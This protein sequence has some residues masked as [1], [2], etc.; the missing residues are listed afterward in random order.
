V[1]LLLSALVSIPWKETA[2]PG[3][4]GSD[5]MSWTKF[6]YSSCQ[7]FEGVFENHDPS[8]WHFHLLL[9]LFHFDVT[10]HFI[11]FFFVTLDPSPSPWP[12]V[13]HLLLSHL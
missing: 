3:G 2:Y 8:E 6:G 5:H 12:L 13:R 7:A 4:A 11:T 10:I 9:T 1:L